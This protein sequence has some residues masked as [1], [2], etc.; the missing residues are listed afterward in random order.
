MKPTSKLW[1]KW[2]TNRYILVGIVFIVWMVFFDNSSVLMHRELNNE[3]K[4][5][6]AAKA[7]YTEMI[8]KDSLLDAQLQTQEG[9]EKYAR[10]KYYMSKDNE[11]VFL[12]EIDS[13]E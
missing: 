13:N 1:I 9:V 3:I 10:E 2:L 12:I 7:F 5:L 4:E 6:E 8:V 11:E